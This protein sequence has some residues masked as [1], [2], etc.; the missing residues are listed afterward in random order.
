MRKLI[1]I[2]L[3]LLISSNISAQGTK[4]TLESWMSKFYRLANPVLSED[5]K[6]VAVRKR[7]DIRQDTL[8][9][10]DTRKPNIIATTIV[11]DG[12]VSFLKN[13]EVL[14]YGNRQAEFVDLRSGRILHY[15]NVVTAYPL[16]ELGKY[17][18]LTKDSTLSIYKK[19]G[20]LHQQIKKVQGLPVS[21]D[22]KKLYV[23]RENDHTYE[24][25]VASEEGVRRLTSVSHAITNLEL[26]PS[27]KQLAI[28]GYENGTRKIQLTLV[29][30]GNGKTTTLSKTAASTEDFFKVTEIQEGKSYWIG[31]YSVEKPENGMVNIWYGNDDN[32][33]AKKS[34]TRTGRYWF[35]KSGSDEFREFPNDKYPAMASLNSERY[36]LAYHLTKGHNF[37]TLEPQFIDTSVYDVEQNTYRP[38]GAFKGILYGSPELICSKS[39]RFVVG[40]DDGKKW[41]VLDLEN[42]S[43]YSIDK[44]G[45]QNPVFS[46]DSQYIFFESEDGVW[47]LDIRTQILVPTKA[48][49]GK[50]V[51]IV[52]ANDYGLLPFSYIN[53]RSLPPNKPILLEVKDRV[54]NLTSFSLL[55]GNTVKEII[56][57]TENRVGN[58]EYDPNL[59]TFCT[60]E[61]N[62]NRSPELNLIKR[63]GQRQ[64]LLKGSTFDQNVS[65]LRQE[66]IRYTSVEGLPLK[67]VLYYPVNYSPNRKYP[68]VVHIY[69]IQSDKSNE[70]FTPSYNNRDGLDIRTLVERGYFVLLP[71]TVVGDAGP[72]LSA[73][74]CVNK[75]L[76]KVS[77]NRNID[78]QKVGLIGHSFGG[79]ET[80]FI[81]T[82]SDRFAAYISGAGISDIIRSYFS[83]NYHYPGPHY[84]QYENGQVN[85]NASFLEDKSR[86]FR[87]NPIYSAEKV[88]APILLWT[89]KRDENVPWDQTTEFYIGL[90][91]NEKPVIALFYKNGGHALGFNSTEKKDLYQKVLEWWDYFLKNWTNVPWIN[92]QMKQG[93]L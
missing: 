58:I 37:L 68:M 76:D 27:G 1:C 35:W 80:N 36:F 26:L 31:L 19:D 21:G 34:G 56:P 29:D 22:H 8:L 14:V 61:E 32:L 9:V 73:L 89:G 84:W 30:T 91:R 59:E 42:Q 44:A 13:D 55:S 86:Y 75:A 43:K 53:T 81:A 28:S 2:Y 64:L 93:A 88:S 16:S 20:T 83:Y 47:K 11:L 25:M 71:D 74:D 4:D 51:K 60:L 46:S 12:S 50:S 48:V 87:N 54:K 23:V 24:I 70:Y 15:D 5:G 72:G 82:H 33:A 78:V 49:Q 66:V 77:N 41:I 38:L 57:F 65:L 90:K 17:G 62:Y 3:L 79:Y 52:N 18:I 67:G 10:V 92:K 45:F 40:S 85:M 39:G 7:Y 6:W 69:Q 63:N